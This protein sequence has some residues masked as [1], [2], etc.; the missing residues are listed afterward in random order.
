MDKYITEAAHVK[1]RQRPLLFY[2]Q[3]AERI[4]GLF[5]RYPFLHIVVN[6][7]SEMGEK[8][9]KT[10]IYINADNIYVIQADE[11]WNL[12]ATSEGVFEWEHGK[13]DGIKIKRSVEDLVAYI[14]YLTDPSWVMAAIYHEYLSEPKKFTVIPSKKEGLW[15]LRL[16]MPR[17]GFRAIYVVK[18]P[19]WFYGLSMNKPGASGGTAEM[20]ISEPREVKG[21]P[22]GFKRQFKE[23]KFQDSALTLHRHMVFL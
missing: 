22:E 23:I 4:H 9:V 13:R 18:K 3:L 15:E 21:L 20:V 11:G 8:M 6:G 12:W 10:D 7:P 1:E 19:L 17:D 14:Y 5:L 2:P 16:K